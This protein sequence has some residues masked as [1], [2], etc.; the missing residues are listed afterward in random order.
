MSQEITSDLKKR[1]IAALDVVHKDFSGLRTGRASPSLLESVTVDAYGNRMHINQVGNISVPEPRLLTV[2]VWDESLAPAV[3]KAIREA[4]L[5]LNPSTAGTVIRVP[6]PEL[7]EERRK[8]LVK[9]AG[10]YAEQGRIAI[11][12]I[13]RDGMD[14]VKTMEKDGHVSKDDSHRLSDEIQKATDEFIKKVDEALS[15]KEKEILHV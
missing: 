12:N 15:H 13:R 7:S 3:E 14:Q 9:V 6:L 10:K 11:R 5:G 8:E 1:M 4:G 2:H